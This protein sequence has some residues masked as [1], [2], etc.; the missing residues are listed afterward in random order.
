MLFSNRDL[1]ALWAKAVLRYALCTTIVDNE[2]KV[3]D[4]VLLGG[5]R[6]LRNAHE[7]Y[8]RWVHRYMRLLLEE[9]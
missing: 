7:T 4:D 5:L 8:H 9:S 6:N 3:D 2:M 1:R